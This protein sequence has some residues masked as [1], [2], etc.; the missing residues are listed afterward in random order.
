MAKRKN[1]TKKEFGKRIWKE[2]KE[3]IKD[4]VYKQYKYE[5][6]LKCHHKRIKDPE[7]RKKSNSYHLSYYY[8]VVKPRREKKKKELENEATSIR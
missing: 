2:E 3:A 8:R 7:Y 5:Q 6:W 4:P 1:E